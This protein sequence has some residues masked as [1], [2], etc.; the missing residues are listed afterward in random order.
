MTYTLFISQSWLYDNEYRHLK[1]ELDNA[2]LFDY[3]P[4]FSPKIDFEKFN[5]R[6]YKKELRARMMEDMRPCNLV[7]C[8]AGVYPEWH[9]ALEMEWSIA[10]ELNIPIIAIEPWG[11]E[12]TTDTEVE[13]VDSLVKWNSDTIV[14]AIHNYS[15]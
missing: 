7:I 10:K 11:H 5:G 6:Q 4:V 15:K 3:V 8:L 2:R 9:D 1:Y 13:T 14:S 12:R